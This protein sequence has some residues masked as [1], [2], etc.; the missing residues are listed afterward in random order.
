MAVGEFMARQRVVL[1]DGNDDLLHGLH[2]WLSVEGELEVVGSARTGEAALELV[3]RLRPDVLLLDIRLPDWSGLELTRVIK[4]ESP[5][6]IVVLSSFYDSGA[7]R[8]EAR[9]AG[10]DGFLPKTAIADDL[11]GLIEQIKGADLPSGAKPRRA[12]SREPSS[13]L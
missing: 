7:V 12:T 6:P 1:V 10:A 4:S 13:E 5:A 8:R 2:A 11:L 3:R 9:A